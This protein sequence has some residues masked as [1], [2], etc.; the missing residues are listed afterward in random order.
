MNGTDPRFNATGESFVFWTI[1]AK[2]DTSRTTESIMLNRDMTV[3][4]P[5]FGTLAIFVVAGSIVALI[6]VTRACRV[7]LQ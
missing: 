1:L 7:K 5:E 2:N 3:M 6:G 4:V